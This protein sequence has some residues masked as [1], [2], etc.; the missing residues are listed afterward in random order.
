[1]EEAMREFAQLA[2][3]R[4]TKLR[5]LKKQGKKVVAYIG[6]FVPEELLRAAGVEPYLLCRGG[7]P[8]PPEAVLDDNGQLS[9]IL[10]ERDILGKVVARS[11]DPERIMAEKPTP[12]LLMT[13]SENLRGVGQSYSKAQTGEAHGYLRTLAL[14]FVILL[15]LVVL[16]GVR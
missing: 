1:M 11:A 7:E 14:G 8:E 9:G 12:I 6:Q 5:E 4:P 10:T 3:D 15:L 2:T 16:G 13:A